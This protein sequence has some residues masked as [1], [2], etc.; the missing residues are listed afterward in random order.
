MDSYGLDPRSIPKSS[1]HR[2]TATFKDN[3]L[4]VQSSQDTVNS[5]H[6]PVPEDFPPL[7]TSTNKQHRLHSTARHC[8]TLHCNTACSNED[9]NTGSTLTN[10][11]IQAAT[12]LRRQHPG[13]CILKGDHLLRNIFWRHPGCS[14]RTQKENGETFFLGETSRPLR[15]PSKETFLGV[16]SRLLHL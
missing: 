15:T 3:Q 8:T 16:A 13:C 6:S 4:K 1:R 10:C 11:N 12:Y 2:T 7:A 9:S 14:R 5:L